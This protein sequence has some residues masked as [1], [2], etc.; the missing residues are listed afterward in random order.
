[1]CTVSQSF[2]SISQPKLVIVDEIYL[3]QGNSEL[4]RRKEWKREI[5]SPRK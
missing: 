3:K 1:M 4:K 5:K 2:P